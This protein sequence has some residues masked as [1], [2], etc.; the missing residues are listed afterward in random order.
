LSVSTAVFRLDRN[1][2]KNT[3]PNNPGLLV[4]TGQQRTDGFSISAA[5]NLAPR[6]KLYGGYA[7][8]DARI[9]ADTSSAPAGRRVGLVPRS[10]LTLWSTYDITSRW[11]AGGG[12]LDQSKMFASFSNAV[13]LPGFARV[14]AVAYYRLKSYRIAVNAENIFN[15]TY[16]PTANGDNNISPGSPRNIHVTLSAGF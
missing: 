8:L 11:G 16:Y 2:V 9:T 13:E 6:W 4:L 5:G 15:T 14:D 3:D 7:I 12:V 10:Q 1:N